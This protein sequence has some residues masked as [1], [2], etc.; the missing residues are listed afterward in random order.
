MEEYHRTFSFKSRLSS[1]IRVMKPT[2]PPGVHISPGDPVHDYSRQCHLTFGLQRKAQVPFRE[3]VCIVRLRRCR[4]GDCTYRNPVYVTQVLWTRYRSRWK[5][6]RGRR[7]SSATVWSSVIGDWRLF[8]WTFRI[9]DSRDL[10]SMSKAL[11][12]VLQ[13]QGDLCRSFSMVVTYM[14]GGDKYM[15]RPHL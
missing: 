7:G 9:A 15:M 10:R 11:H 2:S 6:L 4:M 3:R 8:R 5:E 14:R 13:T 12:L 1:I